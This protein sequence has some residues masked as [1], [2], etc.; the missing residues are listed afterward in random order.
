MPNTP[1][2][3]GYTLLELLIV[4]SLLGL[5]GALLV[6]YMNRR[7]TL[8][9]QAA[10]R[11]VIVDL[12]FAQADALANQEYR[13]VHFFEDGSGYAILRVNQANFDHSF[14]P[15]TADYLYDPLGRAG[16]QQYYITNFTEDKRF[17]G[18][19]IGQVKID[20]DNPYITYDQ[21]GGTVRAGGATPGT[22]G[23]II[24][25]SE[26]ATYRI[27]IA[28]FTGKLTVEQ[29]SSNDS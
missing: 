7:S 19:R 20:G 28:P 8:E 21:L 18:V 23:S 24:V 4:A 13:R 5:A 16:A 29:V 9:T 15:E 27:N 10:V 3:H 6:P 22:G 2:H 11:M 12:N 14:D 26:E 25:T 17:A 1:R